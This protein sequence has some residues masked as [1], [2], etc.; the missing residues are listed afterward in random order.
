MRS[1]YVVRRIRLWLLSTIAIAILSATVLLLSYHNNSTQS[2]ARAQDSNSDLRKERTTV[3]GHTPGYGVIETS[4][5][6]L[7]PI[8]LNIT[9]KD[10]VVD[11]MKYLREFNLWQ[12]I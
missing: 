6:I 4:G 7:D 1:N 5:D 11:P 9:L 8:S 12:S 2:L 3:G 10:A